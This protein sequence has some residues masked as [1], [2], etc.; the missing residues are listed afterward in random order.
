V[1]GFVTDRAFDAI[2][3]RSDDNVLALLLPL[4]GSHWRRGRS[5]GAG[6]GNRLAARPS[7]AR[8]QPYERHYER[9]YRHRQHCHQ[10]CSLH[11]HRLSLS[12][13]QII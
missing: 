13:N 6:P 7:G 8:A 5:R 4:G 2:V 3:A 10:Y 9:G 1:I 11:F 12:K